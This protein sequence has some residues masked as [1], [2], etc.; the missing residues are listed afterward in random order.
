MWI[1]TGSLVFAT[2]APPQAMAAGVE[3]SLAN[4][5]QKSDAQKRFDRG[6]ELSSA[7]NYQ[8]ALVEFRASFDIVAS[9]NT[10]FSIARTLASLGQPAD[11]YVEFGRTSAEARALAS[12][13]K[14][15]TQTAD[16]AE[17]EQRDLAAK[18]AFVTIDIQ[19][20]AD[21]A[22]VK[23]GERE[24]DRDSL[25]F[26]IPVMP[27]ATTIVVSKSGSEVA[28]QSLT[29]AAAEKKAVSLDVRPK[30]PERTASEP[31][32]DMPEQPAVA[33]ERAPSNVLRTSAF[34]AGGVG[35][36]G[37]ATFAIFGAMEKGTYNDLRTACQGGPCPAGK[38]DDISKGRSQETIANV[39]IA[40]GLVGVAAGAVLYIVSAPPK[41]ATSARTGII[42]A[43]GFVG[44]R[45]SL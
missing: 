4:D 2:L 11:A 44:V 41:A 34:V 21:N 22:T 16:A 1:A 29:L 30:A 18:L 12:K 7:Q 19:P 14:R 38:A 32:P 5:V 15:Y 25:A 3:P 28:R 13:E 36:L 9:P 23:I 8:D 33:A 37:L 45:G 24:I 27:G 17:A 42:V 20:A 26:P 35:V 10:H 39:G 40:V 6:R 31:A 43:P